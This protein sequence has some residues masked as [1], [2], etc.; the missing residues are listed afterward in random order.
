MIKK[1]NRFL[2]VS[3]LTL[4]STGAI[5]S[6]EMHLKDIDVATDTASRHRGFEVYYNLCR[7]CHQLKYVKY[8][9][10]KDIGFKKPEI[11]AMRGTKLVNEHISSTLK[12]SSAMRLFGKV[13]PDLSLMAKARE[14]GPSYIYTLLTSYHVVNGQGKG[15]FVE[16]SLFNGIKMPDPFAYSVASPQRKK[17]VISDLKDVVS[18]LYWASDPKADERKSM[19]VWVIGYLILLSVL[20]Y[21]IKRRVWSR[22]PPPVS[23]VLK[24]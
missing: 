9:Y 7:M 12:E 21:L 15:L 4:I 2:L 14:D 16:N 24:H 13:P 23:E 17:K 6:T 10:L 19:G 5:A 18:F 3:V 20:L 22:L 11:D 1:I 8:Q